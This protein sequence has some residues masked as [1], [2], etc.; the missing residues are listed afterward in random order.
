MN[1]REFVIELAEQLTAQGRDVEIHE[2]GE[3]ISLFSNSRN[4]VETAIGA[5]AYKSGRTGRWTF[6]GIRAYPL[7]GRDV[8]ETT[9]SNAR[10]VAKVYGTSYPRVEVSA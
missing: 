3:M 8:K 7:S 10:I 4:I 9:R 2:D 1:A 6:L 5:G